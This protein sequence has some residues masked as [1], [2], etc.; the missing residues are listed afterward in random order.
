MELDGDDFASV[1]GKQLVKRLTKLGINDPHPVVHALLRAR[2]DLRDK[3]DDEA[4]ECP[5]CFEAYRDDESGQRVPRIL[6]CGH[7]ACQNCYAKMLAKVP[8]Q[9]N[10]KPLPCPVCR[11][12][13]EV[14]RGRA[15][16]LPKVFL[17]LR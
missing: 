5:F 4:A 2:D 16:S 11:V 6:R 3:A 10:V 9:G 7:S 8:P 15:D 1:K 17:L 13:T 12:V 14:A